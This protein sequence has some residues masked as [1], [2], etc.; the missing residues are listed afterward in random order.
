MPQLTR[1]TDRPDLLGPTASLL[2][3]Q[4]PS[5]S[6]SSRRTLLS[7]HV[8]TAKPDE[9]PCHLV[10]LD[11]ATNSLDVL[12]RASLLD[13]LREVRSTAAALPRRACS[14]RIEYGRR[15]EPCQ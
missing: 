3:Q 10:L 5:S 13:F 1:L 8:R 12:S 7:T 2:A 11:E 14:R 9:L 15:E 6:A 4:W